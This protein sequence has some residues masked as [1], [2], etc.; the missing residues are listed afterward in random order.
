MKEQS[1]EELLNLWINE[2]PLPYQE[3]SLETVEEA[4]KQVPKIVG[5]LGALEAKLWREAKRKN[6]ARK[7]LEAAVENRLLEDTAKGK[8]PTVRQMEI[9]KLMDD[10]VEEA[11]LEEIDAEFAH[12]EVKNLLD[13]YLAIL[14]SISAFM[15]RNNALLKAG[16]Y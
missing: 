6:S 15:G 5:K 2:D 4:G 3:L 13:T 10:G 14:H 1:L 7:R 9:V 8:K 16:G 11:M 12:R